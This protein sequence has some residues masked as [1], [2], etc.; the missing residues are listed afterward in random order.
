[1]KNA[2]ICIGRREKGES[3]IPHLHA[4]KGEEFQVWE[5]TAHFAFE[6]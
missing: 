3:E 6:G 2:G 4:F 5:S 1:L